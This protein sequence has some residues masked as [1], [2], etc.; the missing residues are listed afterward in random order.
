[1]TSLVDDREDPPA[2]MGGADFA[3]VHAAGLAQAD[4][5]LLVGDV[6]AQ[7]ETTLGARTGG[8]GLRR[9][10]VGLGGGPPA[11]GSVGRSSS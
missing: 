5:A 6:V 8:H 10:P 3:V 7:A 1:M 11:D 2:G 9:R 4:G